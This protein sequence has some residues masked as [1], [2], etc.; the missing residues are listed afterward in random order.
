MKFSYN[1]LQEY[2]KD[3][4]PKPKKLAEILSLRTLEVE[5][6]EEIKKDFV[7][8]LNVTPNR[9]ADCSSHFG[10]AREISAV[11][12][13]RLAKPVF[14]VIEE[15]KIKAK[16]LVAIK[17]REKT[18]CP[19]Y[20]A[21]VVVDVEVKD[22]PQWLR[23][24]LEV[25]GLQSINNIVDIANYVMLETGQPLHAFDLE[26]I[27]NGEKKL[28]K[29]IIVRMAEKGEKITTL[30]NKDYNL[31]EKIL[32]IA[33]RNGP[34]AIAGIKG[35]K[36]AEIDAKT[37]TV[38]LEAAN[39][40]S[41]L[42]R[43]TSQ[44]LKLKTDAS[45]R[46]ERG[47]D[48][49]LTEMAIDRVV[50]LIKELARGKI[51]QGRV[52]FYPQKLSAKTIKV[53]MAKVNSLLGIEIPRQAAKKILKNLGFTILKDSGD[54]FLVRV[55]T[56]RM[57]ISLPQDLTEEIGRIY[58]YEKIPA[59]APKA[60]LIPPERNFDI[61]WEEFSRDILKEIG[62]SEV[63]NY[64]FI[65]E[66]RAKIF[67]Y[68]STELVEIENPLSD[69]QKYLVPSLV[70]NLLENVKSNFKYF[71][72]IK[73]FELGKTFRQETKNKIGISEKTA[74]DG[75]IAR[76]KGD[77]GFYELKGVIEALL[78]KM[79]LSPSAGSGQGVWYDDYLPTPEESKLSVWN[80]NKCAEIKVDNEE[81]GFLGEIS[82]RILEA[83]KIKGKVVLFDLDFEK[84]KKVA[85]EEQEYQ[86][87]SPYPSATRDLSLLVSAETKVVEVLNI[88]GESGGSLVR[89]VDLFDIY[90]GEE[91]PEGRKNFAFHL[92]YQAEDRTLQ[93]DEIE[94]IHQKIISALE[95]NSDWE[96]R[97]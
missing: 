97:K 64:S 69:S 70:P 22:S 89:D 19:R 71:D 23:E 42:I 6:V 8:D 85:I 94:R 2:I 27:E 35:G 21:R 67:N 26:K 90:E 49:N 61:F 31:N 29:E 46:F 84:L 9:A 18:A 80:I 39:F 56:F 44:F 65:G 34:L 16:D 52:D 87:I 53:E 74:L 33:D 47:V 28:G 14:K 75:L 88:I 38:V 17:V 32:I 55:P 37:K 15:K 50:Q 24:K 57:D 30:D 66:D 41:N 78:E 60:C 72:E 91:L 3:T 1:W 7:I 77:E 20:T 92:I 10:L 62:F 45:W 79:G 96:V 43:Q 36:R 48:P 58:G 86:P 63:Y 76:K 81:I 13:S 11:I 51:A 83:L 95:E 40:S 68:S 4:L 54:K 82:P 12:G 73:I 5:G 93:A 59:K 25:C